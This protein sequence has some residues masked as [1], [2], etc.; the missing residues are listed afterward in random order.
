M[1]HIPPAPGTEGAPTLEELQRVLTLASR[2]ALWARDFVATESLSWLAS[3]LPALM[4]AIAHPPQPKKAYYDNPVMV[5]GFPRSHRVDLWT[6][7]EKAI[8]HAAQIVESV[9]A[10]VLLTDAV[11]LLGDAQRKVAEY[12]DRQI[13][14]AAHV[15]SIDY[16]STLRGALAA[17]R[18]ATPRVESET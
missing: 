5:E 7:A 4:A 8:S 12:T 11:I 16:F 2:S 10:D 13:Q 6:P 9:G 18:A 17:H 15:R 14:V 1:S 3:H